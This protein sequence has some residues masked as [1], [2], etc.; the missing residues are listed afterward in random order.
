MSDREGAGEVGSEVVQCVKQGDGVCT[1][2]H[3]NEDAAA[4]RDESVGL[5]L[6]KHGATKRIHRSGL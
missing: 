4:G 2:G 3:G 6:V 5:N 1:A